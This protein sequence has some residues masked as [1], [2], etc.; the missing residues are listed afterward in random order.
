M[1]A[2]R[3]LLVRLPALLVLLLELGVESLGLV[4][5]GLHKAGVADFA[6]E[7]VM[8]VAGGVLGDD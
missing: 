2:L 8:E 7:E 5:E 4:G 3:H 1:L 6:H